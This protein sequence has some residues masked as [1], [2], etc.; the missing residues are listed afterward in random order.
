M[1]LLGRLLAEPQRR[2]R[3]VI[4]STLAI[5][6]ALSWAYTGFLA[7]QMERMETSGLLD[8]PEDMSG[9]WMAMAAPWS[10]AQWGLMIVMWFVMMVAMML[11]SAAPMIL[12][13]ARINHSCAAAGEL[14]APTGLFL[15]G[16][17]VVWLGFSITAAAGQFALQTTALTT[18]DMAGHPDTGRRSADRGGAIPVHRPQ[19]GLPRE[20]PHPGRLR[21][22]PLAR[23]PHRRLRDGRPSRRL[24]PN[25]LLGADGA[26]VR[27]RG[28]EP[29]L[30]HRPRRPRAGGEAAARGERIAQLTGLP[31]IGA[32]LWLLVG[33]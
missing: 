13:V 3:A 1:T 9:M 21:H 25:L 10:V 27:L 6:V 2:D 17:L 20:M 8:M 14:T 11:P 18:M 7:W 22:R 12:T 19:A 32:G 5:L 26:V 4:G 29:T 24:L 15:A 16:Y 33:S 31:L 23:G 30:D 28:D